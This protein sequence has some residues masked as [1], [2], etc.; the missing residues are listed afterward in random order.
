MKKIFVILICLIALAFIVG[1]I[2]IFRPKTKAD[3]LAIP[4]IIAKPTK[5]IPKVEKF[6]VPGLMY[7]YIRDASAESQLGQNLSVHPTNFDAQLKHLKDNDYET[8]K[9]EDLADPKRVTISKII[10]ENKKPIVLTFDDG[11]SDAYTAAF[12]AL[13]KYGFTGTFFIIENY[14]G[15]DIYISSAQIDEMKKA[16]MEIGSHTLSHPDLTK[17]SAA[18]AN[19]QIVDSK[20]GYTIFCYPA[21]KFNDAVVALVKEAGYKVAVTTKIGIAR[22]TSNL[23][24][25]PRVRI[26]NVG[27][28]AFAD[29]I[30]YAQENGI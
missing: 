4:S 9:M 8:M 6:E 10:A 12:P 5:E 18:D 27:P 20:N 1:A 30:S 7:H 3:I 23:L 17:I 13:K 11:Y 14:T 16:G 24:E 15:K 28:Q 25:I 2:L 29:K 26:E 19:S 21:G 22:E